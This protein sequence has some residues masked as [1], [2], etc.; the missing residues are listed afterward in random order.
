M[1]AIILLYHSISNYTFR[2]IDDENEK[3]QGNNIAPPR[4]LVS[5]LPHIVINTSVV[6]NRMRGEGK[7]R[8]A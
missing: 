7:K 5:Q 4:K 8:I 1:L 3:Q 2:L 6:H